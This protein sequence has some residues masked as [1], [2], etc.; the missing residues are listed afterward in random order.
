MAGQGGGFTLGG[1]NGRYFSNADL[2]GNPD[3]LRRDVRLDFGLTSL[4]PGGAG[5][6]GD[7]AF[8]SVPATNFSVEWSGQIIPRFSETYT[9]SVNARGIFKLR[10][11]KS[12]TM[13]WGMVIDQPGYNGS[14]TTG[15]YLMTAGTTYDLEATFQHGDGP[16]NA[17]LHWSSPSTP[18]EVIDPLVESGINNPD[19]TAGF[20]N[21]VKGAR[22]SW[23]GADGKTAPTLD[24]NG[25][26]LGDCAYVFQESLNQ[27]QD[28][29]PLM[30]GNISFSFTGKA[31]VSVRGNVKS[32]SLTYQYDSAN[33]LTTGSFIGTNNGWNATYIFFT[34]TRR[35]A[36]SNAGIAN[37]KLMRPTAPDSTNSYD[38]SALFTQPMLNAMSHFS[39]IRHQ[40]VANQQ[41][42]WNERTRPDYFNQSGGTTSSPRYE[43][44]DA[45][46]NGLSWELKVLF[47]NESGRDLMISIP[48]VASGR[49]TNDVD[50][51]IW[52]LANLLRYGSDGNEPYTTP[53]SDPVYPPLNSNLRVYLELENELWNWGGVFW[54]DWANIN[55]LVVSD[56]KSNNNDFQAINFD[57]LPLTQNAN[58]DYNSINTWRFRKILLRLYQISD[59]FRGVWGDENMM[60]RI[61][62]L[63]E[64]QY[65]NANDTARLALVFGD[66]YF[67]NGDGQSHVANPQPISHWLWGGGG[68]TYYGAVNGNGLTDLISDPN[69]ATPTLSD[70]YH[71]A[72]TDTPWTFTGAAGIAL[73]AGDQDDIPPAFKGKQMG[74]ITDKGTASISVTFPAKRTSD[75]YGVSF[76][77]VNRLPLGSTNANHENLRVYL[78]GTND[79]TTRTFSQGNGYTPVV[80]SAS[81]PWYANNVFWTQ[82]E[83]YYTKSF[84]VES[85]STHTITFKGMGDITETNNVNQTVFLGEVRVTSVDRIFEDGMPGGGE[86]AGQP[87]GLN[88]QNTMNVE[89]SW[90]K[91]FGLEQLSYEG[92]WSLGGDDGGSWVQLKAKYG[93]ART[94]DVQG[95]FMDMFHY[96]GSAV[97]VFGTY[98]QW[99]DWSDFY[100]QQGLLDVSQYPIILG[101]DNR[102]S[103]LR[104]EPQNGVLAPCKLNISVASLSEQADTV[105]RITRAG[106]WINWNIITPYAVNYSIQLVLANTNTADCV[107]L[108]DDKPV[109]ITNS[110]TATVFLTKGLHSVKI[111][112]ISTT[113]I[114]AQAV[115]VSCIAAPT[116]PATVSVADGDSLA[117]LSW[118]D[119]PNATYYQ[120][121]YGTSSGTYANIINVTNLTS[122]TVS[123]LINNQQYF[124]VVLAGSETGLSIPSSEYGVIPLGEKTAGPL[125]IWEF[126]GA[127]GNETTSAPISTSSRITVSALTRGAGFTPST[128]DWAATMRANHFASEPTD[129]VYG[130]NLTQAISKKQYYEFSVKPNTGEK[131]S[132]TKLE[133]LTFFQNAKGNV[134]ITYSVDGTN[135]DHQ[136]LPTNSTINTTTSWIMD[137]TQE[138]ALQNVRDSI[139][140]RIY[141]FGLGAYEISALGGSSGSD[142]TLTGLLSATRVALF[143]SAES[144]TTARLTWQS[145]GLDYVIT[146]TPNISPDAIWKPL[147]NSPTFENGLWT[148]R[149]PLQDQAGYFQLTQ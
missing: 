10:L 4:P 122:L 124:F 41:R 44:G 26:P 39:V 60:T 100:A 99:P 132:L 19:W 51:Y 78:D 106:G 59:I 123:N 87:V 116:T 40:Y 75:I 31:T 45:S 27:G 21:I 52:K 108:V 28:I 7:K 48:T 55:A 71:P 64:W 47:A 101:I 86:A 138:Q 50:S 63:Y 94:S 43:I 67:N 76:K 65:A 133:F 89:A 105:G 147:S 148:V 136:L 143:I 140:F 46:N 118:T 82:S 2:S 30:R 66:Q 127:V 135:F 34:N 12:G 97:N 110:L 83:Y 137:L 131:L 33:N 142:L 3:F 37:L 115:I 84:T 79:I 80:Y 81:N 69:F 144:P 20:A 134:G 145:N 88:I 70:G 49:T 62:P 16:W 93:D 29:D 17:Q 68:A 23:E 22:N 6:F 74:Y 72:P 25:W 1:P 104:P 90:A 36:S 92:G 107:L 120:I 121:R 141:L 54:T 117:F 112:S 14:V 32:K 130:T 5:H 113:T 109:S 8:Q 95:K 98:A 57:N 149:V 15:T 13:D 103:Q 102:A 126:Y 96:A 114:Q 61:R 73:D 11:R 128:S 9:F 91:A 24:S 119:V 53:V 58:G 38:P 18:E 77:A 85:G 146:S 139:V 129:H 35:N 125:A 111:R 56:L 42:D